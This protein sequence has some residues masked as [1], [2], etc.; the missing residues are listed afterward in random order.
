MIKKR[1]RGPRFIGAVTAQPKGGMQAFEP[2][3]DPATRLVRIWNELLNEDRA[4]PPTHFFRAGGDSLAALTLQLRI[5]GALGVALP[6]RFVFEHPT[7]DEVLA[8]VRRRSDGALD[9]GP[10]REPAP[11]PGPARSPSAPEFSQLVID[12]F[13]PGA[14]PYL[15]CF[16]FHVCGPLD[17]TRLRRGIGALVRRHPALRT[18]F[19]PGA[20]GSFE[21]V[22]HA[23]LPAEFVTADLR[24]GGADEWLGEQGR[25]GIDLQ[26]G[27]LVRVALARLGADEFRLL[28]V[29]HHIAIDEASVRVLFRELDRLYADEGAPLP[30]PGAAAPV[31]HPDAERDVD[32]KSVV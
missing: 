12:R 11:V 32:R 4:A 27:P 31:Q 10:A 5:R 9:L 21:R 6:T 20:D 7:F 24:A 25:R 14:H 26:H 30:P 23:D 29:I 15:E 22:A 19:A 17:E 1:H 3:A 8:E 13:R 16:L 2:A 18:T 28:F